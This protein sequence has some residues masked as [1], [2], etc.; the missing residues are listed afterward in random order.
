[1]ETFYAQIGGLM[2]SLN[3]GQLTVARAYQ[4]DET[5]LLSVPVW[6]EDKS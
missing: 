6:R 3:D 4:R 5:P 2:V 1:M